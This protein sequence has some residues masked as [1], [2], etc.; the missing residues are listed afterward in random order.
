MLPI[1]TLLAV[2]AIGGAVTL[3]CPICETETASALSL[4]ATVAQVAD[5]ASVRIHISGMTC[6]SCPITARVA[7]KK[8]AGVYE[9]KVTLDD[10]LGVVRYDPKRVT[11]AQIATHLTQLTGY[12]ATI[13]P[14][15]IRPA[16]S[17]RLNTGARNGAQS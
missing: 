8:L 12:K 10:S 2:A 7:L 4:G 13:L 3:V 17:A 11:P 15:S 5:T 14:D 1:E 9:V 6:G 16:Q